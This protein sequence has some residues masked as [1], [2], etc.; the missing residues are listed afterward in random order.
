MNAIE[1][2]PPRRRPL[3]PRRLSSFFL[4]LLALALATSSAAPIPASG[5]DSPPAPSSRIDQQTPGPWR[6]PVSAAELRPFAAPPSPWGAGHRGVD[7][8]PLSAGATIR[9][10][11]DGQ[12]SF[13]GVVVDRPVLSIEHGSGYLSS[14]EP[15]EGSLEV[16]D[17]V[18]TGDPVGTLAPSKGHCTAP[19]LH[20]GVRLHGDYINPLLLTGDLEPS[21][22]LPLGDDER[23]R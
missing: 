15:V 14:F 11:A 21:V 7:L 9:A 6:S 10:P 17:A 13:A 2:V 3:S 5:E 1:P 16:G 12:V 23:R 22:L 20:W 19:C 8:G 4:L 18:S